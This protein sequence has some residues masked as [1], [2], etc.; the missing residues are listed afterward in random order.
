MATAQQETIVAALRAGFSDSQIAASLGITQ[1]AVSQFIEE[2]GLKGLAAQNSKF[3]S[4]DAKVTE[5]EEVVLDKLGKL[6]KNT[7]L[8][9]IK[10]TA[11]F[12][13]LN[14]AKRRSLAE[15]QNIVNY[16]DVRLVN[17]QLPQHVKVQVGLSSRNEV[18][19]V[20]GRAINTIPAGRLAQLSRERQDATPKTIGEQIANIL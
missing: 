18:I 13:T 15:G 12:K 14:G 10:L 5:L 4:I 3:T 11:I 8:D 9:P 20:D 16:N 1:S 2:H 17:L 6:V 19:E 7:V